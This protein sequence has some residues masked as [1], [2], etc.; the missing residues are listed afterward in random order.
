MSFVVEIALAKT[1]K[2]DSKIRIRDKQELLHALP[3]RD[4]YKNTITRNRST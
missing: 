1:I 4:A 3:D 2:E